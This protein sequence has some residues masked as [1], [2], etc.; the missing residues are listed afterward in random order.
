MKKKIIGI[1]VSTLLMLAMILPAVSSIN[2]N[3]SMQPSTEVAVDNE[4]SEIHGTHSGDS[5][6]QCVVM[7]NQFLDLDLNSSSPKPIIVDTPDEFSWKNS[8]GQDWTTITK[9]Q[10]NCGSCWDFAAIGTFESII[11]I[12]E[13]CAILDP[14]LSEQYVLSCLP[15]A[16]SCW[17]G[18]TYHALL[19]I[20]ETS[21]YR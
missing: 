12:R 16:G 14:D 3:M 1:L 11:N 10:G 2:T 4:C 9:N 13:E 17:G 15:K 6:P 21:K 20:M 5:F 7:N 19:Y 18:S 8:N